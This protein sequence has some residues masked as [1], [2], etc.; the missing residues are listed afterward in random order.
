[1]PGPERGGQKKGWPLPRAGNGGGGGGASPLPPK[2]PSHSA[3][4]GIM[5]RWWIGAALAAMCVGQSAWAQYPPGGGGLLPEPAPVAPCPPPD[6]GQR[7]MPGPLSSDS[8]PQGP[9]DALS[10]PADIHTA[11]GKGPVPGSAAFFSLGMMGLQR[12]GPGRSVIAYDNSTTNNSASMFDPGFVALN[13]TN[14]D[15]A[16]NWGIRGTIGYLFDDAAFELTG[17][18]IGDQN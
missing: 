4:E 6:G 10:L 14:L 13:T 7:F 17:F 16:L 9:Q 15:P 3:G 2:G 11:W 8:A 12:Q 1:H 18:Y 5:K